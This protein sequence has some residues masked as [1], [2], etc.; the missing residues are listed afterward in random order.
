MQFYQTI[1]RASSRVESVFVAIHQPL[2]RHREAIQ[3]RNQIVVLT[4]VSGLPAMRAPFTEQRSPFSGDRVEWDSVFHIM[5]LTFIVSQEANLF[6]WHMAVQCC[7]CHLHNRLKIE[8]RIYRNILAVNNEA[9]CC[10]YREKSVCESHQEPFA[11][12]EWRHNVIKLCVDEGDKIIWFPKTVFTTQQIS[13]AHYHA[14]SGQFL[15]AWG[16]FNLE[17]GILKSNFPTN[18]DL[19][20]RDKI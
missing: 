19:L 13:F 4:H 12:Y 9:W 18:I 15:L 11:V 5:L 7:L 1:G 17:I 20:L 3:K 8:K 16:E 2:W 14:V 6:G 10:L